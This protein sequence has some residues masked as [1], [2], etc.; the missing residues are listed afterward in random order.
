MGSIFFFHSFA[1][2]SREITCLLIDLLDL[3]RLGAKH[4]VNHT[5]VILFKQSAYCVHFDV[6]SPQKLSLAAQIASRIIC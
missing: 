1:Q 3:V 5:Q 2:K 6:I 4:P